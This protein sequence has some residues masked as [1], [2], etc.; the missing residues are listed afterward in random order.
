MQLLYK[1][2]VALCLFSR[3]RQL[4]DQATYTHNIRMIMMMMVDKDDG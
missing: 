1:V 4:N 2:H 3:L